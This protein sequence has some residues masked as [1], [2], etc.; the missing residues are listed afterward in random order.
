MFWSNIN[1]QTIEQAHVNGSNIKTIIA[2][3]LNYPGMSN[4]RGYSYLKGG[5]S[6]GIPHSIN[7]DCKI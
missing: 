1:K 4:H 2:N 7:S 6:V 3:E 5:F